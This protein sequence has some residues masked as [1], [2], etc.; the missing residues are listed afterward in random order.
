MSH[1]KA[2]ESLEAELAA[3]V[4]EEEEEEVLVEEEEGGE[5]HRSR[6]IGIK[7]VSELPHA[8]GR[9]MTIRTARGCRYL[10]S[11]DYLT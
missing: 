6:I 8:P 4:A 1:Q 2:V 10:Q 3:A 7:T 11:G 9:A 5:V